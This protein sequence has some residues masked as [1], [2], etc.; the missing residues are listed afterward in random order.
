MDPSEMSIQLV[1]IF[2]QKGVNLSSDIV[3]WIHLFVWT[4]GQDD[5]STESRSERLEQLNGLVGGR[6]IAGHPVTSSS[7]GATHYL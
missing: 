1:G 5:V 2:R 4:V 3:I 7:D 6:R